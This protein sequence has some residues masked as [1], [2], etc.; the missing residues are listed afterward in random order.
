MLAGEPNGLSARDHATACGSLIRH[1]RVRL[2]GQVPTSTV[3]ADVA[4]PTST[5]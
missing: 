4:H 2:I 3:N 5:S 1:F